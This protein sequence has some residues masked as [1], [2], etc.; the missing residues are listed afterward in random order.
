MPDNYLLPL[1]WKNLWERPSEFPELSKE[2][3]EE[4]VER[5]MSIDRDDR[6]FGL[7]TTMKVLKKRLICSMDVLP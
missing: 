4:F 6:T 1:H 2:E 3:E 5:L 7:L